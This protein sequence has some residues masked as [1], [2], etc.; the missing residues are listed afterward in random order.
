MNV[1]TLMIVLG[2][3]ILLL[4]LGAY[5]VGNSYKRPGA[6]RRASELLCAVLTPEQYGQLTQQG[7]IDIPS[8]SKPERV[9]RVPKYPGRVQVREKG[10]VT[11]WLCLQPYEWVPDADVVAI[12]KLMIEADEE[13]YLQKANQITPFSVDYNIAHW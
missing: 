12:H 2:E 10:K 3:V 8:P 6:K 11:M 9:Y 5:I 4:L 1:E 7:H 13:T